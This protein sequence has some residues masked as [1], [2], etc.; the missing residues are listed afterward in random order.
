MSETAYNAVVFRD[1]P[2]LVYGHQSSS[3]KRV[4]IRITVYG[5]LFCVDRCGENGSSYSSLQELHDNVWLTDEQLRTV[6][7]F[8]RT[9]KH[10]PT[11]TDAQHE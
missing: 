3:I 1:V 6:E 2:C 11:P 4:D 10:H 5:D 8:A 9:G 7:A